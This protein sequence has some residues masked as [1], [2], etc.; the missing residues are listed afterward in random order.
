[1]IK[2]DED[3]TVSSIDLIEFQ[4]NIG[5]TY[6]DTK[7]LIQALLH[8]S[9]FSGDKT[10]LDSFKKSNNLKEDNY[11]KLEYLGDSVLNLIVA[12]YSYNNE[13]INLYA[14][15]QKRTIEGVLTDFK[16]VLVSNESLKPLANKL[17]LDKYILHGVLENIT[18]I[19][20]DVIEALIGSIF[21]DQDFSQAKKF[22][23]NFF[24]LEGALEKIADSNPKG[25]LKEICDQ[26]GCVPIYELVNEEGPD[27][28]KEFTVR[29]I[30]N[31][32]VTIGYGP[33]IRKAEVD[34]AKKFLQNYSDYKSVS[35]Q[36]REYRSV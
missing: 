33:K 30:C 32:Q 22:V 9:L 5:I 14:K 35:H 31:E 26:I 15:E 18:E 13:I 6:N 24:D 34:A 11:E 23:Y 17:N 10:K 4:N 7:Y 3:L 21:V 20:A 19:Y 29:L 2:I 12:D 1:M 25:T 8:G 36:A 27:H 16:R 28:N